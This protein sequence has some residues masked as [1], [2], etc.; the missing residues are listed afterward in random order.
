MAK[1]KTTTAVPAVAPV[2]KR[3]EHVTQKTVIK[4]VDVDQAIVPLVD[5]L[6]ASEDVV[7]LYS[8]EGDVM[9]SEGLE[10]DYRKGPY[11]VFV[12]TAPTVLVALLGLLDMYAGGSHRCDASVRH[13]VLRYTLRL[14][15]KAT[16]KW[17]LGALEQNGHLARGL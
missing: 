14:V 7:T 15:D 4:H 17:L 6:N 1:K 13:G 11:V 10:R 12:C 2:P 8:C 9:Y 5:F 3:S 16:L